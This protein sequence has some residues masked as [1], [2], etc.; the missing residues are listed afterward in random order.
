[1]L[2]SCYISVIEK[3]NVEIK[4]LKKDKGFHLG[5]RF[6]QIVACLKKAEIKKVYKIL[7]DYISSRKIQKKYIYPVKEIISKKNDVDFVNSKIVV[8]TCVSGKYDNIPE[9]LLSFSNVD[10]VA[11]VDETIPKKDSL[12]I[13]RQIP[14]KAE[15]NNSILKNRYLKFHP[16][17]FLSEYDYSIY[18]DGNVRVVS[19]IR[20]FVRY[21]VPK[22]GLAMHTHGQRDCVYDEA[23]VCILYKR[24]NKQKIK[25]QIEH[26][27]RSGFPAH[28]GLNEANVIVCDL[29]NNLG[30]RLLNKWWEEFCVSGS[31]RDQL[32]WPYVLWSNGF[33]IDDVGCLGK[34]VFE[35][36]KLEILKHV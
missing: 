34:D 32:A 10:Y 8:Y 2:D 17:E 5:N 6:L 26:Y 4:S 25:K 11:F 33:G 36:S 19:D 28:F 21:C 16:A 35:N 13:Y 18:V 14:Q 23:E 3:L 30:V 15:M 1:M 22:T 24:G 9:P 27:R 12:W 7:R 29:K 31:F 20:D